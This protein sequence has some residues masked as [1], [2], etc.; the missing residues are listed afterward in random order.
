MPAEPTVQPLS[1][2][3]RTWFFRF[4]VTVFLVCVPIFIFYAMG[5]RIDLTN[6]EGSIIS[7]GGV[8]ISADA[9]NIEIFVNESRVENMR[10][11]QNAAYIQ[12]LPSGNHRIHVQGEGLNTWVKVLPVYPH[13]V[14][15]AG[16]F[17]IPTVPQVRLITRYQNNLS[18]AIIKAAS[19]TKPLT[20]D[21][22]YRNLWR[23]S[24]TVAISTL[25]KN[26]EFTYLEGLFGTST[27]TSTPATS[28]IINKLGEELSTFNFSSSRSSSNVAEAIT[29]TT[30]RVS[31]DRM[32]YEHKEDVYVRWVG[33][34][35]DTPSYFCINYINASTTTL[36]YGKHVSENIATLIV[37]TENSLIELGNLVCRD[38]IR[39]DRKHQKV[40][41]F[42]FLP[43]NHDL[44]LMHLED[45]LYVVEA[46]DRSWQNTQ[47][48]YPGKGF[49][50]II[51]G[52]QIFVKEGDYYFEIYTTLDI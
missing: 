51:N 39:I 47:I 12:N 11:F 23:A 38:Q 13:I 18:E 31:R 28:N 26:P 6:E 36:R 29:A 1:R 3:R 49:D 25:V 24:S 45:G 8:Y 9:D 37:S 50:V 40:L 43:S 46:D 15:E 7:V 10:I 32:L 48:L 14:T 27:S 4:L 35:K 44:I 41:M 16:A 34:A 33:A 5:Y 52:N 17:N 19:G 2:N 30:T 21:V 42:D 20:A 22:V